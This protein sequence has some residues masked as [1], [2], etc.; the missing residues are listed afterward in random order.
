MELETLLRGSPMPSTSQ[1]RFHIDPNGT[2]PLITHGIEAYGRS[3]GFAEAVIDNLDG[4]ETERWVE[5]LRSS[6]LMRSD[7]LS[8]GDD[9]LIEL[10]SAVLDG[11]DSGW[12]APCT[13]AEIASNPPVPL[14]LRLQPGMEGCFGVHGSR[15]TAAVVAVTSRWLQRTWGARWI[16]PKFIADVVDAGKP[17]LSIPDGVGFLPQEQLPSAVLAAL[18]ILRPPDRRPDLLVSLV[19]QVAPQKG[20]PQDETAL[21]GEEPQFLLEP[22]DDSEFDWGLYVDDWTAHFEEDRVERLAVLLTQ[23]PGVRRCIQEDRELILLSSDLGHDRLLELVEDR[24]EA[25]A[26]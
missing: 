18:G 7:N 19:H 20:S 12:F 6:G 21:E 4:I 22:L 15:V 3:D 16:V 11:I 2:T 9:A 5:W 1:D 8:T 24:W 26:Q 14:W 23:A 10:W 17:V 13:W 25:T